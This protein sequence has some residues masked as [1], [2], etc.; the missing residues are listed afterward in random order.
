[1]KKNIF[2]AVS[3]AAL[4]SLSSTAQM[5]LS[6][7]HGMGSGD[8]DAGGGPDSIEANI[9]VNIDVS[10]NATNAVLSSIGDAGETCQTLKKEYYVDCLGER[11]RALSDELTSTGDYSEAKKIIRIAS[12]KLRKLVSENRD[13]SKARVKV[14]TPKS[15][16]S[17]MTGRIS[18]IKLES[19]ADVR[20][21]AER[22][23]AEA[24]TKLL[25]SV[26]NSDRRKNHYEK[27]AAAIGS[28]TKFLLR[29]L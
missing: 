12:K 18:P 2:I 19:Q 17:S 16:K 6:S 15:H 7:G 27:I 23:I 4:I 21:Q 20:E 1:M 29:S 3:V 28:Q 11:L 5:S 8:P 10:S 24:Q 9:E 25:R 26:A 22:I 14:K 13:K